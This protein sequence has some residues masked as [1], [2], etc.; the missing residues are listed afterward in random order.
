MTVRIPGPVNRFLDAVDAHPRTTAVA[1]IAG[2]V[3]L[4]VTAALLNRTAAAV[5]A[6]LLLVY[7]LAMGHRLRVLQLREQVRQR[8][9]DLAA[10]R[11]EVARLRAGDP[12]AP[13]AQLR[14]IGDRGEST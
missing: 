2:A 10:E 11:A 6:G 13:T 4:P 9:Y 3:V 12:S 7:V 8:D 5:A 14:S 1:V